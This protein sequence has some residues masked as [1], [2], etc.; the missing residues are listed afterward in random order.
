MGVPPNHPF[1]NRIVHSKPSI[2]GTSI[3]G[4]PPHPTVPLWQDTRVWTLLVCPPS[5]LTCC[6]AASSS[7]DAKAWW[8]TA[9][10]PGCLGLVM[11]MP[12]HRWKC[13]NVLRNPGLK[14]CSFRH[15][16]DRWSLR[17]SD[18]PQVVHPV[19][20]A[21]SSAPHWPRDTRRS[22]AVDWSKSA[23]P[24]GRKVEGWRGG[25]PGHVVDML[26]VQC[27][28]LWCLIWFMH[29]HMYTVYIYYIYIYIRVCVSY[30]CPVFL[31]IWHAETTPQLRQGELVGW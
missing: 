4:T 17:C 25:E 27:C 21:D 6:A 23:H 3:Y 20:A 18:T 31:K 1:F 26:D 19:A 29:I 13:R 8:C 10:T 12:Q 16:F 15:S 5:R 11:S 14:M 9:S 28:G 24:E 30:P 22:G 2:R 7:E